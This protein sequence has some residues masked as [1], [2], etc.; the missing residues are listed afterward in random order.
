MFIGLLMLTASWGTTQNGFVICYC[1]SLFFYG[2]GV[3]GVGE[4]SSYPTF[5]G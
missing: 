5:G 1:W 3:G 2:V 4:D